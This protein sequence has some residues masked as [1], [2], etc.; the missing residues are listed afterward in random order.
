MS[1]I[2]QPPTWT[3]DRLEAVLD[4]LDALVCVADMATHE[5]L[6]V[7]RYGREV[8]GDATDRMCR[9]SLQAGK[10]GLC[11]CRTRETLVGSPGM[12]MKPVVWEFEDALTHRWYECRDQA[13]EWSDGR[14]VRMEIATDI[15]ERKRVEEE[16]R[17][18]K[19]SLETL[20]GNLPG[21]AYRCLN[22]P[23]WRMEF[24]S[25]GCTALTGYSSHDLL[26]CVRFGDL[27]HPDDR[28][29]VWDDV[30]AAIRRREKFQLLYRIRTASGSEKR[31]WE[32]GKG[33]FSG[34][35]LLA[36]EGFI[37]D[38][39]DRYEAEEARE[40]LQVQLMQAQ[41]LESIGRLAGGVAH[42]F[43]NM[44]QAI[45]GYAGLALQ[46]ETVDRETRECIEEIE[47][48][49]QSSSALTRQ[50]LTFAR[51]Q[52]AIPKVVDV[53]AA[54]AATFKM[55]QRLVGEEIQ[56]TWV[57][58]TATWPVM[59]DPVQLDQVLAN[60]AVNARDAIVG[61]GKITI[62]TANVTLRNEESE[63]FPG[64]K[65]G[66]YVLLTMA[67]TGCGM[68]ATVRAHLFEPFF[69]TKGPGEG[70]GLGLA[71]V[72]GIIRQNNGLIQVDSEPGRGS[73]FRIYLPRAAVFPASTA[74][75]VS[76]PARGTET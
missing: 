38:V 72:Y 8:W 12:P 28:S 11:P 54:L 71:T 20:L 53:N 18:Q 23:D 73:T 59:V 52:T 58:G 2:A 4:S 62:E 21:M 17:E 19:R 68:D 15:T 35:E 5:I 1:S 16:L 34:G 32:S 46:A 27:V 26:H 51:K 48:A 49:A 66:D 7:N 33:V 40:K 63:D 57:P 36:L 39:T 9:E 30:Q 61:V 76:A 75:A 10:S 56:L 14:L 50:L 42:D 67:D 37:M 24:V 41:K 22:T 13:I 47:K 65:P 55:L 3:H 64:G 29:K 44:L 25:E 6:F 69:T 31:V 74:P 70:T 60:L 45:L 43:N